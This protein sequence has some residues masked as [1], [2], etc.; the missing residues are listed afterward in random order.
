MQQ[1]V[2]FLGDHLLGLLLFGLHSFLLLALS[3]PLT[4]KLR[5]KQK[6]WALFHTFSL[7]FAF[8]V[9]ESNSFSPS[10]IW[11]VLLLLLLVHS[12][13]L[14]LILS[15]ST[16]LSNSPKRQECCAMMSF[17]THMISLHD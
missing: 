13:F 8:I 15:L 9:E 14:L 17:V 11:V 12:L 7:I 3:P 2:G 6:E 1:L 5:R 4:A 10:F 16:I